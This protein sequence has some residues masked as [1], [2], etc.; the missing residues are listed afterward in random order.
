MSGERHPLLS[1]VI[2]AF[3]KLLATWRE[4]KELQHEL[5]PFIDEGLYWAEKY[6]IMMIGSL[7]YNMAIGEFPSNLFL[8]F[9]SL[10]CY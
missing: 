7:T 3:H 1:S 9:R 4:L 2:G 10:A 8:Q 5:A 6:F